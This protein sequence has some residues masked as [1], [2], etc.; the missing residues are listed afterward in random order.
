MAIL[1]LEQQIAAQ[2]NLISVLLGRNPGPIARGRTIDELAMPGVP[3]DLPS[4]L[5]ERRPDV[6][7]AEAKLV[8]AN[9]RIGAARAE[10]FP[11]VTIAGPV[12]ASALDA[13]KLTRSGAHLGSIGPSISVPIFEGGRIQAGVLQAEAQTGEAEQLYRQTVLQAFAEVA[14][15][16]F[17]VE[18]RREARDRE[19]ATVAAQERAQSLADA[20]FRGGL[21]DYLVVLDAQRQVLQSRNAL[22]HARRDLLGELVRL[23]K[24]LGGGWS[25]SGP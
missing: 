20:Q 12:G 13:G 19:A 21:V 10:Y 23:H 14:D 5:L 11:K 16:V 17:S 1:V 24:A 22:V 6:R 3:A 9:A 4:T 7:S 8:A 25:A 15:A 2:E 18:A